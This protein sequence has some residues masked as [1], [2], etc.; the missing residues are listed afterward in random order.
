MAKRMIIMLLVTASFIAGLGYVKMRQIKTA[1]QA[2]SFQ[3]PP[4][5]ITT[6]VAKQ[7]K[8]SS[9]FNVIGTM[10]AVQGVT[11]S[12]DLPGTVDRIS[13]DSG[14]SVRE[15]DVLIQLDT[16]Q[17]QAQLAAAEA[18]RDLDRVNFARMRELADQGVISRMEYDRTETVGRKSGGDPRYDRTQDDPS[19]V[20][21]NIGHPPSQSRSVSVRW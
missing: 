17:E 11:V 5:S 18:Q 13:F 8:W 21:R 2:A 1:V 9:T 20:L 19:P 4:E 3:P 15:G 6:I 12:A 7:E 10:V 14:K 16:R